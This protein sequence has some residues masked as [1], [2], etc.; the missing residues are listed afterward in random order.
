MCLP[1][2]QLPLIYLVPL[3]L[4]QV[5]ERKGYKLHK[6]RPLSKW[7]VL[8]SSVPEPQVLP[9]V[10]PTCMCGPYIHVNHGPGRLPHKQYAD[11]GHVASDGSGQAAAAA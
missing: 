4:W 7:V 1:H 8:L 6:P 11:V 2:P 10:S 9:R 3:V 5:G